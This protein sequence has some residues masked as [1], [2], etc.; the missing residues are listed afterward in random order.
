MDPCIECYPAITFVVRSRFWHGV[1]GRLAT[2]T[3][4]CLVCTNG[5]VPDETIAR[6]ERLTS[7]DSS[8]I[9][10]ERQR[11]RRLRYPSRRD[12][13]SRLLPPSVLFRTP[14][15]RVLIT[16][17]LSSQNLLVLRYARPSNL[18]TSLLRQASFFVNNWEE[19]PALDPIRQLFSRW[20]AAKKVFSSGMMTSRSEKNQEPPK[21]SPPF[22]TS[23]Y[24]VN[25]TYTIILTL[26]CKV[27]DHYQADLHLSEQGLSH[28]ACL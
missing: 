27:R 4:I 2:A 15:P 10:F 28:C 6:H 13:S 26:Y 3:R 1:V 5:H 22:L 9:R 17:P 14:R 16:L 24:T 25:T 23:L 20:S 7:S 12:L 19:I 21:K 18:E 8:L 11:R